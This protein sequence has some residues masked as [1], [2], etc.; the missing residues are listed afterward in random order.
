MAIVANS[1]L[2]GG[3]TKGKE[4]AKL[5]LAK[6]ES[7]LKADVLF[8]DMGFLQYDATKDIES[9]QHFPSST[10][11]GSHLIT[12]YNGTT[13]AAYAKFSV[14][15]PTQ[16]STITT[17]NELWMALDYMRRTSVGYA[18]VTQATL[19]GSSGQTIKWVTAEGGQ[20]VAQ[21]FKFMDA[22]YTVVRTI[23]ISSWSG[24]IV[25]AGAFS[26][27]YIIAGSSNKIAHVGFG[28]TT[29]D[30]IPQPGVSA[31]TAGLAMA[32]RQGTSASLK[33][34]LSNWT[35]VNGA[36]RVLELLVTCNVGGAMWISAAPL[37]G[38]TNSTGDIM[39]INTSRSGNTVTVTI[40]NWLSGTE[41]TIS[42]QNFTVTGTPSGVDVCFSKHKGR[43]V[44]Q[45]MLRETGVSTYQYFEH[46]VTN[47]NL[48]ISAVLKTMQNSQRSFILGTSSDSLYLKGVADRSGYNTTGMYYYAYALDTRTS[49]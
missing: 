37:S 19:T 23:T 9:S 32:A 27:G 20:G 40:T 46:V 18:Q 7:T 10:S 8:A 38:S 24:T 33:N 6:N 31:T 39:Q 44:I 4:Y 29:S 21:T 45:Y 34:C 15:Y 25:D 3:T 1:G 11:G 22:N 16:T 36:N 14:Y 28:W 49:A 17:K 47:E 41:T 43:V 5:I 12:L 48:T 13:S 30:A 35:T 2:G 26:L 42:A